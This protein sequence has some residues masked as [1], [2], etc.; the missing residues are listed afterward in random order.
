MYF[1]LHIYLNEMEKP[2]YF[3][4]MNIYLCPGDGWVLPLGLLADVIHIVRL[5]GL[6]ELHLPTRK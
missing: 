4:D 5:S 6:S 1:S 2:K 3:C